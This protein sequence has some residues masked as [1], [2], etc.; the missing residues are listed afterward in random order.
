MIGYKQLKRKLYDF[1]SKSTQDY[2]HY[3]YA[4]FIVRKQNFRRIDNF[5]ESKKSVNRKLRKIETIQT[6]IV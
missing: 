2:P 3:I 1:L 5:G 6:E 4:T